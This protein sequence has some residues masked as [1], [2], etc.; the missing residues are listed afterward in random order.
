M[1]EWFPSEVEDASGQR[2]LVR[3]VLWK[4]GDT[5][6]RTLVVVGALYAIAAIWEAFA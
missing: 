6:V 5:I 3:D 4:L 1:I 2:Y